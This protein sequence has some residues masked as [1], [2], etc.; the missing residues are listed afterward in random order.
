MG[1]AKPYYEKV[2]EVLSER[3]EITSLIKDAL[4]EA[5]S[6]LGYYY[7]LQRDNPNTLL[8]WNKVLELDPENEYG[9]QVLKSLKENK[10]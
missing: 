10:R 2:V 3:E 9:K 1:I 6:Y 7:Y 8:Y 5:Y 4:K